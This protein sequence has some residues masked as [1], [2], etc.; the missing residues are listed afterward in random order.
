VRGHIRE[1]GKGTW[2]LRVFLGRDPITRRDR[3]KTRTFKGG[4][5]DA[6][7]ELRALLSTIDAGVVSEGTFGELLERWYLVATTSRDWSPKTVVEHRRIIDKQLGPLSNL[8]LN[9]LRTPLIDT[10]YATL[11][12]Q[13]G[14]CGHVPR[15]K[16]NGELCEKGAPLSAAT[17]RRVHAVVHS[18]LEQAVAWDLLLFNPASKASPGRI[19]TPEMRIP[20]VD[21]VLRILKEAEAEDPD[22]AVFLILA[23]VT[24][25][26]RGELC[27]LRW[28]D[29]DFEAGSLR[30]SRVIAL[31]EDGPVERRKPKTRASVRTI[32]L[33]IGTLGVLTAHLGRSTEKARSC[34]EAL[35]PSAFI[36]TGQADGSE[37]WRPDSTSRR[38][39]HV[40]QACGINDE[41]HLHSLRHFVVT[42][43]LGAGVALPQVAGRVGHSGGGATTLAVYSHFQQAQDQ[44]VADLL[45][46][47]LNPMPEAEIRV[48]CLPSIR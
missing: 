40:R 18:A 21:E 11:R 8:A 29:V 27:A 4:K 48:Q 45:G 38:F 7:K 19:E 15:Q 1:R 26:R 41:I 22:L 35:S 47:I 36:F 2:E 32:A 12:S 10:Y 37:P 24:G 42:M 25:A 16:H 46:R 3:Y 14:R 43:L 31:G 23:A 34:G 17:V 13:G 20:T 5:K 30:I 44:D 33:D 6:E 9:K 39:R 28:D